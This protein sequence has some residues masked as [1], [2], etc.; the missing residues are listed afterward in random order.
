MLQLAWAF[1]T[2]G[3]IK[4]RPL[5]LP[6]DGHADVVVFGSYDGH[7]YVLEQRHGSVLAQASIGGSL[8]ASPIALPPPSSSLV[9]CTNRG[10]L[11]RWLL[12]APSS[13]SAS[14]SLSTTWTHD[15]RS[16]TFSTPCL[17]PSSSLLVLGCTDGS[18]RAVRASDGQPVWRRDTPQP[19]FS[20]PTPTSLPSITDDGGGDDVA[21]I[22]CHDGKL[23]ALRLSDGSLLWSAALP[24]GPKV[25]PSRGA[26]F[27][28]P[29]LLPQ[30]DAS[31][32]MVCVATCS[33]RL[34]LL[35][36]RSGR[37]VSSTATWAVDG[38]LFSSPVAVGDRVLVGCRDDHLYCLQLGRGSTPPPSTG[39]TASSLTSDST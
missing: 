21:F 16:P 33:G 25:E 14:W 10:L 35:D 26:I 8:F 19:V 13:P 9:L 7:L 6:V 31:H 38:E 34:C 36:G 29:L 37:L 22:G 30:P 23:R 3:E 4:C 5:L 17:C 2:G 11:S 32:A 39:P 12:T 27:S 28:K 24:P 20:S 1:E 15:L 18:I